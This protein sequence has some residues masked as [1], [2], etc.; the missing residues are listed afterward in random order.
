MT[1]SI[2]LLEIYSFEKEDME[3]YKAKRTIWD[4]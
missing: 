2:R 1:Y 4:S 3:R